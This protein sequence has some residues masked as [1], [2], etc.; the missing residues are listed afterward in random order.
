MMPEPTTPAS[1]NAAPTPS[2]AMRRCHAQQ[3]DMLFWVGC[4]AGALE[5]EEYRAKLART[6]PKDSEMRQFS[7]ISP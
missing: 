6:Q 2:A 3:P 7:A 4:V 5:D 1:R